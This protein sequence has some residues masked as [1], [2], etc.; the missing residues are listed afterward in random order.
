MD[1]KEHDK[2]Y[3]DENKDKLKEIR[4]RYLE[5]NKEKIKARRKELYQ[6]NKE[7]YT[8]YRV[9]N[10][11][12]IKEQKQAYYQENKE[13]IKERERIYSQKNKEKIKARKKQYEIDNK[14][15]IKA[16]KKEYIKNNRS[17]ITALVREK[18]QNDIKFKIK[19]NIS[20]RF[21]IA[22]KTFTNSGKTQAL[23]EYGIDIKSIVEKLGE[24]PQDGKKYHIDHIF[25]VSAFDLNN[26]EHIKACWHPSN[27]RWLEAS[28]N[29]SKNDNYDEVLFEKYLELHG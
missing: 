20:R 14:D 16:R 2:K 7:Y 23:K 22:L 28:E 10:A 3:R 19:N 1:R 24:P 12:K 11:Q 8:N 15:K 5:K 13:K 25:P 6:E 29:I 9:D 21:L 18:R 27:L 4:K 17:R 26:P